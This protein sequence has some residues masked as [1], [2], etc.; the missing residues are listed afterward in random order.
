ML[1][2]CNVSLSCS[3]F[4]L[5]FF[6]LFVLFLFFFCFLFCFVLFCFYCFC[7]TGFFVC[8]VLFCFVLLCLLVCLFVF[9]FLEYYITGT[10]YYCK[11]QR[12]NRFCCLHRATAPFGLATWEA[13]RN[14]MKCLVADRL[15]HSIP[16]LLNSLPAYLLYV[17]FMPLFLPVEDGDILGL[18]V[19]SI[20]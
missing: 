9:L 16:F 3:V 13:T 17:S 6:C 15:K 10:Y 11:M 8:F 20:W 5:F 1:V 18:N 12:W 19:Q 4:F 7:F 2:S 14:T